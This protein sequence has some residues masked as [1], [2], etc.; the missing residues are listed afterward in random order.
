MKNAHGF[1]VKTDCLFGSINTINF[2]RSYFQF[3]NNRKVHK[4]T[5][6]FVEIVDPNP[7]ISR[8]ELIMLMYQFKSSWVSPIEFSWAFVWL[9]EE[10][11]D[12]NYTIKVNCSIRGDLKSDTAVKF[13]PSFATQAS[14]TVTPMKVSEF[15][16]YLKIPI[17]H[18][19][20]F[21]CALAVPHIQK[22]CLNSD[23]VFTLYFYAY[24][25]KCQQI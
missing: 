13:G 1:S 12:P 24:K 3:E 22:F 17:K 16:K 4:C 20:Q 19:P 2:D 21:P 8:S 15:K 9:T 23:G 10:T 7:S 14:W 6:T 11:S 25:E 5:P 18:R